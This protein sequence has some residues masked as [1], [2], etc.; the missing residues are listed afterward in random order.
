MKIR[1]LLNELSGENP[2][3]EVHFR[4]L[5]GLETVPVQRATIGTHEGEVAV[6]LDAGLTKKEELSLEEFLNTLN[7][8][9]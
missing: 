6:F 2:D 4:P 1:D 5:N 9:V 7:S 3:R 8:E